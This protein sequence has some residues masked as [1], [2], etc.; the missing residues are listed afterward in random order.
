MKLDEAP[1]SG[2]QGTIAVVCITKVSSLC[3]ASGARGREVK[4]QCTLFA[5]A[6]FNVHFMLL[7][8]IKSSGP[9]LPTPL[10]S[11]HSTEKMVSKAYTGID[12]ILAKT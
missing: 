9:P 6:K 8:C 3:Y 2:V 11:K 1:R 7:K 5:S 10:P 4:A 12:T